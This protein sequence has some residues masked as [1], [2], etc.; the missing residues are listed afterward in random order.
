MACLSS[1]SIVCAKTLQDVRNKIMVESILN[2]KVF[3]ISRSSTPLCNLHHLNQGRCL[4]FF[5]TKVFSGRIRGYIFLIANDP[6]EHLNGLP[7]TL[8]RLKAKLI[9]AGWMQAGCLMENGILKK[10]DIT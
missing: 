10:C 6:P 4:S 3:K 8:I 9:L 2:I 1:S 5:E 7:T